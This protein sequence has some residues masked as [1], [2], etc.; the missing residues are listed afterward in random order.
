MEHVADP[1]VKFKPFREWSIW[2]LSRQEVMDN[3]DDETVRETWEECSS[4]E[5]L[6]S[7]L[8]KPTQASDQE[9]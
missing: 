2:G 9:G 8:I 7:F 5:A 4:D 6:E 1:P 3:T